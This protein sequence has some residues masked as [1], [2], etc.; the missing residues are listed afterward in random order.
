MRQI[1]LIVIVAAFTFRIS[2]QTNASN[3][4][5][6]ELSK[7]LTSDQ[8]IKPFNLEVTFNKTVHI[9]FPS[10]VKYIDLGSANIIAGITDAADNVVRVKAAIKDFKGETNFSVITDEGDFYSFNVTYSEEPQK[11]SFEMKDLIHD[12]L[13]ED[14]RNSSTEIYFPEF[15]DSTPKEVNMNMKALYKNGKKEVRHINSKRNGIQFSLYGIYIQNDILYF[16]T[17]IKNTSDVSFDIDFIQWKIVDKKV[18]RRTAIQETSIE[19][20]RSFNYVTNIPG[21]TSEG[22]VFAINK[23]TIPDDKRLIVKVFEKN[24]GRHQ[25][26]FVENKDII[27]ARLINEQ[28]GKRNSVIRS[29]NMNVLHHKKLFSKKGN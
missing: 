23:F 6:R 9:I 12:H 17:E 22:A 25:S 13:N 29:M 7:E 1:T 14:S 20:I 15:G 8:V 28:G 24:G 21:R 4:Q 2:A 5:N 11:L 10:A 19:P 27:Q 16:Y 3:S 18:A 26:F